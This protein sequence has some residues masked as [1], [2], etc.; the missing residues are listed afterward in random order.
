MSTR[1]MVLVSV[2]PETIARWQEAFRGTMME[3]VGFTIVSASKQLVLAEVPFKPELRQV[4]GLFHAG[5][6]LTLAD[7]AATTLANLH[8]PSSPEEFD[9]ARF[10]LTVQLN[11]NFIRNSETTRLVAESVPVHVGRRTIVVRTD[12]R[13]A[14]GRLLATVT[15]TL[16]PASDSG[17]NPTR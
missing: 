17:S 6:L 3:L 12:V 14:G 10:P 5:V 16:V 11:A 13:D 4:T 9:P 15:N 2:S 7:T 1:I 8:T